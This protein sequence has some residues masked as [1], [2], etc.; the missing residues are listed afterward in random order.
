MSDDATP[1]ASLSLTH[2]YYVSPLAKT[3]CV[4][5]CQCLTCSLTQ[6]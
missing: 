4:F 1:L 5:R 6:G 3:P 2:V